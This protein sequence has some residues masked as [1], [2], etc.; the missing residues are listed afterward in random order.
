[1]AATFGTGEPGLQITIKW[2]DLVAAAGN[3]S[4]HSRLGTWTLRFEPAGTAGPA[5]PPAGQVVSVAATDPT[6]ASALRTC[7]AGIR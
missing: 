2:S 5:A 1:M 7:N 4:R 6:Y 3:S